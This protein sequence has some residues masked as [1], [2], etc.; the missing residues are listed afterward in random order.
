MTLRVF[1]KL[2]GRPQILARRTTI[3]AVRANDEALVSFASS[4]SFSKA[5]LE[6]LGYSCIHG[7]VKGAGE[8]RDCLCNGL[9]MSGPLATNEAVGVAHVLWTSH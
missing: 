8:K 7:P 4:E 3:L 9:L 5:W 2:L 1:A 6:G